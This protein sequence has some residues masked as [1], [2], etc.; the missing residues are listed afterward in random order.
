VAVTPEGY[1]AIYQDL[2]RLESWEERN[3]MRFYKGKCRFLHLGRNNRIH[4]YR[5]GADLLEGTVEKDLGV[6]VDDMLITSEQ[7]ALVAQKAYCILEGRQYFERG[8]GMLSS[9]SALPWCS[10]IWSTVSL[11][12]Q[13]E[14]C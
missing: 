12:S 4:Q 10:H 6:L 3:I 2:N 1:A 13:L 5:L 7:S 9:H 14:Y 8:R 11:Q